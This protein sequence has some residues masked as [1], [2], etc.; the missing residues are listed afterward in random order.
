MEPASACGYRCDQASGSI[1]PHRHPLRSRS[2]EI[3]RP[4]HAIVYAIPVIVATPARNRQIDDR[5]P[6]RIVGHEQ[7]LCQRIGRR[8]QRPAWCHDPPD[9]V[10]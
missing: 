1:A 6:R 2:V 10:G 8:A 5:E 7:E 9:L 4:Q 3:H